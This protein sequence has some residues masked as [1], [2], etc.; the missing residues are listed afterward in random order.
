[1]DDTDISVFSEEERR[2]INRRIESASVRDA[3][4]P[5]GLPAR[6][7][8][9][10]RGLFPF[11][12]NAA[13]ALVLGAGLFCLFSF[14]RS[15]TADIRES[16]ALLGITER[17]LI[18]EIRREVNRRMDEKD[19]A[20]NAMVRRINEVDAELKRLDSQ[21]SLNDEQ[22]IAL[23]TLRGRQEEYR[24]GLVRLQSERAQ[25]LAAARRREAELFTRTEGQREAPED[26]IAQVRAENQAAR[27]EL[28]R[29]SEEQE[30]A[31]LAERQIA[32]YYTEV[33]AQIREGQYGEAS[34]TLAAL[35]EFLAAPS[36]QPVKA[37]QVRRESDAAA[38][39]ALSALTAGALSSAAIPPDNSPVSAQETPE[40]SGEEALRRQLAAQN[41][42]AAQQGA[43][44]ADQ[45]KTLA[46]LRKTL[47]SLESR[48]GEVQQLI[49]ERDKQLES[50]R[51][52]INSQDQTIANLRRTLGAISA[53]LEN[54]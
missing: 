48:N 18:Q 32:V 16:G 19:A 12:V 4:P 45:E 37:L 25:I 1:M 14:H 43:A 34:R 3:S 10:R 42:S 49:A 20:I 46:D 47:A 54:Q 35:K 15:D 9:S 31:A 38:L 30:K 52:Q 21:D 33:S 24:D 36:L 27:D 13:G 11:L 22:R 8:A 41:A 2:E 28:S 50:L 23:E 26:S 7:E 51:A 39:E 29:L 53:Q 44:L 40:E 17:K 6:G 5:P